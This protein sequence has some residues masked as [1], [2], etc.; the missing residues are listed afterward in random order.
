MDYNLKSEKLSQVPNKE[1]SQ[2]FIVDAWLPE[3]VCETHGVQ[4]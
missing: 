4:V 3:H 1:K 2:S